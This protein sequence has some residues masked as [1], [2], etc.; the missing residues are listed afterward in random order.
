MSAAKYDIEIEQGATFATTL[1]WND[2]A[3]DPMDLTGYTAKMHIRRTVASEDLL[4]EL[5][6]ENDRIVLG[7]ALGTVA[8]EIDA[9]T[10][11]EIDWQQAVYDLEVTALDGVVTRLISGDVLVSFGVTR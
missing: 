1:V 6:T 2:S 9:D 7:G 3:G 11:H 10:T 8:L 4:L 5:S